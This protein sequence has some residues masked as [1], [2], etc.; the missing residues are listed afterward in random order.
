[1]KRLL[2]VAA[3]YLQTFLIKK[4]KALGYYV[5]AIDGNPNAEG[6]EFADE[7]ACVNITD[8]EACVEFAKSKD[9]DGVVT[10]A[11]D[12][13]VI[14]ASEVANTLGL[15]GINPEVARLIK[16]KYLVRKCL[17]ENTVDDTEQAF[18]VNQNTDISELSKRIKYPVMVKPCDGSG[19]RGASRV[20]SPN[21]LQ[22]AC[23]YAMSGSITNRAEIE[24]F[25]DGNEYGI[26]SFVYDGEVHIMGVMKKWMT[27]APNYAELG[28]AIPSQLPIEIE[29]KVKECVTK[30]IK[31][32]GVNFGSVNM[33][34]LITKKGNVHIVDIGAR[35]GG[36]LIGSHIIQMGTGVDYMKI[37]INAA[38]GDPVD[39]SVKSK[40]PVATKLLALSPGL[41]KSLPDFDE[42]C[43]NY[44]VQ[45]E[46]HLRVG[47]TITPYRTNLDGNGY[48]I[49]QRSDVSEAEKQS[50]KVLELIDKNIVRE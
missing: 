26:E 49:S 38:V 10:A 4:A 15:P 8:P 37:I 35:M 42:I 14:S 1:M 5:I 45:I 24:T 41:I 50:A 44:D 46:H 32:L 31:A 27:E 48:I 11:S 6:F 30:A 12:Y 33:D 3:G 34:A 19:S 25:I 36:N 13:G 17:Y 29:N 20:D 21:Q 9:I 23:N 28:H 7:S 18:E 22:D 2:V 39:F 40:M 43:R 47:N 16:N